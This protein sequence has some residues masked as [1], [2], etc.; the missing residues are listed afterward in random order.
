MAH[1]VDQVLSFPLSGPSALEAP[2]ELSRLRRECPVSPITFPSGDAG[3]LLTRYADVKQVLADPR[4]TRELSAPD[5]ARL[6]DTESGGLFNSPMSRLIPQA[7]EGHQR[8]RRL[9]NRWFTAKR[10]IAMRPEIE[11]M[12]DSLVDDLVASGAPADLKATFSFPL[13]VWVICDMLGVPATDRDRFATWSDMFLNLTR[14]REEEVVAS[15]GEFFAYLREHI[16]AKKSDPGDDILSELLTATDSAGER[17]TEDTLAATGIGLLVAGHETTANMIAKMVAMLL[18]NRELW[19]QLLADP[20]LVR[21]AV[22][23]SLRY[24]PNPGLGMVRY[25]GEQAEVAGTTFP[26]GTTVLCSMAAANRDEDVFTDGERIDLARNP[27]PHLAFG[28]GAHSCLGQAL[29]RTELQVALEV[30]LR[31]L[32]TMELAVAPEELNRLEGLVVG[33]LREVP[34]RW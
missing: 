21:H 19:E 33:G 7:G 14:Y 15:M 23:E 9:I 26:G 31:R 5:A 27:N 32:P 10:M 22:E 28:T 4:F 34:V 17:L 25:I 30:L 8:W 13:P 2:P 20:S 29:A 18:A 11:A 6:T 1:G 24:D 16:E 12:A 3:T